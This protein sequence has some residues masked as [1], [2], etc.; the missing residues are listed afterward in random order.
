MLDPEAGEYASQSIS[1]PAQPPIDM[2]VISDKQEL[3]TT[4][5]SG[6]GGHGAMFDIECQSETSDVVISSI[7]FHTDLLGVD[8]NV[9]VFTKAGS[10]VGY[11]YNSVVW[12]IVADTNVVGKGYYQRTGKSHFPQL[13]SL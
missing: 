8:I 12:D 2:Y 11:G 1:T 9:K 10:Y 6:N 13:P 3:L 5:S 7:D 4:F